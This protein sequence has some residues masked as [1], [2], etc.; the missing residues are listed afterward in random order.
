M[1]KVRDDASR[2]MCHL[3]ALDEVF[4]VTMVTEEVPIALKMKTTIIM[5]RREQPIILVDHKR[6]WPYLATGL[7]LLEFR[8]DDI[9]AEVALALSLIHITQTVIRP[10]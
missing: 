1:S 3:D 4:E 10:A 7:R 8:R 6:G 5:T 9:F 2:L